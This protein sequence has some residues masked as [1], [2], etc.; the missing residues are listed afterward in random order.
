MP[1][2]WR[3]VSDCQ[4]HQPALPVDTIARYPCFYFEIGHFRRSTRWPRIVSV[5][6]S[7]LCFAVLALSV[8][9]N[10]P[11]IG[12]SPL[13]LTENAEIF[14]FSARSE[15]CKAVCQGESSQRLP[16]DFRLLSVGS[17]SR[18]GCDQERHLPGISLR[19]IG[20]SPARRGGFVDIA[21]TFGGEP[22]PAD[23]LLRPVSPQ[24]DTGFTTLVARIHPV[25][26]ECF[27][28]IAH[29][30]GGVQ[31]SANILARPVSL[32]G[33]TGFTTLA[34]RIHPVQPESF[35]DI[36]HTFGRVQ[37]SLSLNPPTVPEGSNMPSLR[38]IETQLSLS[39]TRSCEQY[40]QKSSDEPNSPDARGT[41]TVRNIHKTRTPCWLGFRIRS[42]KGNGDPSLSSHGPPQAP[43]RS[44][45]HP[46]AVTCS[47]RPTWGVT[48]LPS[49]RPLRS[50][51]SVSELLSA[52]CW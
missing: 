31:S 18:L 30:S 36:A 22:F 20:W 8:G 6:T 27:V 33:D 19:P 9:C 41:D 39:G 13:N 2:A 48:G 28:D 47:Q 25:G 14:V 15:R 29:T 17:D 43:M 52:S 7:R 24:G 37:S 5:G 10:V 34:A 35:V 23:S 38:R 50:R 1:G 40:P 49:S 3:S 45:C 12:K 16:A 4:R 26:P 51:Q 21:H 44:D 42:T 11:H 32:R 46:T